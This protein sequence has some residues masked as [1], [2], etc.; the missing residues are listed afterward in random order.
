MFLIS[1]A[2]MKTGDTYFTFWDNGLNGPFVYDET[3][4]Y[5]RNLFPLESSDIL[6]AG[7]GYK[8][9]FFDFYPEDEAEDES[10]KPVDYALS[11]S[12]IG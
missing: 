11:E 9:M 1:G 2:D 7:N 12:K 3:R 6:S 5:S 10:K 8:S 4:T